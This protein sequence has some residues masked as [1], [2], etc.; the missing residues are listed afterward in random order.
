MVKNETYRSPKKRKPLMYGISALIGLVL[1]YLSFDIV[2]LDERAETNAGE[3]VAEMVAVYFEETL[4]AVM[5][6]APE[7]CSLSK[8]LKTEDSSGWEKYGQQN[9]IG[10]RYYFLVSGQ[11]RIRTVQDDFITVTFGEGDAECTFRISTVY[12]FGNEIRDA[13]GKLQLKEVGSLPTF[14]SLSESIN[15]RV[16]TQVVAPFLKTVKVGKTIQMQGAFALN[17]RLG[18]DPD[19]EIKPIR[20]QFID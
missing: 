5:L 14:N 16:R 9:A 20:L 8:M 19:V 1:L 12:I 15:E 11:G 10:N 6:D 18:W 7:P 17:R 13:S 2:P 3:E 4:P